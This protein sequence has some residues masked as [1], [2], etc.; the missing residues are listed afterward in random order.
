MMSA[1][2]SQKEYFLDKLTTLDEEIQE[3]YFNYI[4]KYI[5]TDDSPRISVGTF[6]F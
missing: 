2:S 6:N 5:K 3:T 1:I 4:E